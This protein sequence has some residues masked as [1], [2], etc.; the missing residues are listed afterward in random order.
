MNWS[1][2]VSLPFYSMT[3]TEKYRSNQAYSVSTVKSIFSQF[4]P[5]LVPLATKY[6]LGTVQGS[7]K[8][9]TTI[10]THIFL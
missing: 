6:P 3:S 8:K 7:S 5:V 4:Y 10:K 9:K 1:R 2:Y